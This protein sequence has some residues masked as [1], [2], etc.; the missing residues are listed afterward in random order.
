LSSIS[1]GCE[2]T[3]ATRTGLRKCGRARRGQ[4]TLDLCSA[5]RV[6]EASY[7]NIAISDGKQ[8]VVCRYSDSGAAPSLHLHTGKLYTCAQGQPRLVQR[9]DATHAVIVAS[10]P[11]TDDPSWSVV[12]ATELPGRWV[13]ATPAAR[14]NPIT[15]AITR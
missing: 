1:A 13:W 11:L 5:A 9:D 6:S 14:V 3:L 10:E 4:A 15:T 2:S 7:F 12:R 8:A